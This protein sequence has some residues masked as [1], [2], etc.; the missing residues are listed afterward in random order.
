MNKQEFTA[1][2]SK[3]GID[4]KIVC[5]NDKTKDDI[6]CV[7]EN[8]SCVNVFYRERG[9]H[10]NEFRFNTLSDGLTYLLDYILKITGKYPV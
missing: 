8:E 4:P 2:L 6:F 10:F 9:R 7:M 1:A 3:N 5:F